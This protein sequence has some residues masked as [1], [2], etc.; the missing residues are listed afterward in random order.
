MLK[1]ML[2]ARAN[3][4]AQATLLLLRFQDKGSSLEDMKWRND[5]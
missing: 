1:G 2:Q 4:A 3:L 5:L